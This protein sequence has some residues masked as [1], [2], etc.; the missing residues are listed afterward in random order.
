MMDGWNWKHTIMTAI[1]EAGVFF[2]VQYIRTTFARHRPLTPLRRFAMSWQRLLVYGALL[3]FLVDRLIGGVSSWI[4]AHLPESNFPT[5]TYGVLTFYMAI[6]CGIPLLFAVGIWMSRRSMT[7]SLAGG[8][9]TGASAGVVGMSVSLF[10]AMA[11]GLAAASLG[12]DL[13]VA[14]QSLDSVR[15][16]WTDALSTL[17]VVV[18]A[19][20]VGGYLYGRRSTTA[21]YMSYLLRRVPESTSEAIV[22]LAYEEAMKHESQ[23]GQIN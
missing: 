8:L 2:V 9:L 21:A 13:G 1:L 11:I 6:F 18:A 16:S 4:Y 17:G 22:S 10:F 12:L 14:G 7:L 15:D 20:L 5:V 3:V 23:P 19:S